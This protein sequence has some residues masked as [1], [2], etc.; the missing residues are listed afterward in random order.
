MDKLFA[1][2][3]IANTNVDRPFTYIIPQ[4]LRDD[5]IPGC[6][7]LI[8]FGKTEKTGYV[9]EIRDSTGLDTDKLK[10]IISIPESRFNAEESLLSLAI[11][12]KHRYGVHFDKAI[13][14]VMPVRSKNK[15]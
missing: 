11:W 13:T 8:E 4:N 9:L 2:I 6:P 14:T 3:I 5:I 1:D 10:S 12:I 15:Q 7:V